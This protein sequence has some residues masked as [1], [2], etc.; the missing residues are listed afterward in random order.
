M[1]PQ[2]SAT[3][4]TQHKS[5]VQAPITH[6]W[7]PSISP[8]A[9]LTPQH[10]HH[11]RQ[12]NLSDAADTQCQNF[13]KLNT[14][15]RCQSSMYQHPIH[16]LNTNYLLAPSVALFF[17]LVYHRPSSSRPLC[18]IWSSSAYIYISSLYHLQN[19]EQNESMLH[20]STFLCIFLNFFPFLCILHSIF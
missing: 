8:E 18:Q 19:T 10:H 2:W 14:M 15:N 13:W 3:H 11:Q 5:A 9:A 1:C 16:L 7:T 12:C 17:T 4:N 6:E 20:F